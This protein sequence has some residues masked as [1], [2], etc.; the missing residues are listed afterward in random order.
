MI[1]YVLFF[2]AFMMEGIGS[3]ISVIGLS[4]FAGGN[5]I[6]I[7]IGIIFDIAKITVVSFLYRAWDEIN[8]MMKGYMV[9]VVMVLIGFTSF[10]AYGYLSM[11]F[12]EAINPSIAAANTMALNDTEITRL[13]EEKKSLE[14]EKE[15]INTQIAQ[16]NP[17]DVKGRQKLIA[18]FRPEQIRINNRIK[19]I[20]SKTDQMT[21]VK[22]K[23]PID[24]HGG[25]IITLAKTLNVPVETISKYIV[26][27]IVLIFDPFA[28][29]IVI[30]GNMAMNFKTKKKEDIETDVEPPVITNTIPVE[31]PPVLDE[32]TI[33]LVFPPK[34][35]RRSRRQQSVE[36]D[37]KHEDESQHVKNDTIVPVINTELRYVTPEPLSAIPIKASSTILNQY[38]D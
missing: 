24:S 34:I 2:T 17:N 13:L 7:C 23:T 6:I 25:P 21:E 26:L 32:S 31:S 15:K 11:V 19:E 37:F 12:Q 36:S 1:A 27:L 3:W 28:I 29:S 18:S 22:T 33:T 20:I 8:F 5:V 35:K 4:A 30:A 9:I 14:I 16:L 38:R 10:G